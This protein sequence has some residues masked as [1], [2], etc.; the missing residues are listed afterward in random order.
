LTWWGPSSLFGDKSGADAFQCYFEPLSGVSLEDLARLKQP[1]FFPPRW[2]TGN[3]AQTGL[4]KWEGKGSRAGAVY[5]LNRPETV[6]VSDFHIGAVNV[7]PWLPAHHPMAGKSLSDIYR[8]LTARYLKP[9]AEIVAACDAFLA[10]H[11]AQGP[12]VAVHM[13]GSDKALE[14]PGLE[15]AHHALLEALAAVDPSWR[16]LLL[17]DD[18][19]CLARVKDIYGSRV[20][21]TDCQRTSTPEGVHYLA[22]T[23]PLRAGREIMIDTYLALRADRFIGNGLSNVSAMIAVMKDWAAGTC[24]LTGRSLLTDRNLRLY[25]MPVSPAL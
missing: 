14:D 9:R 15:A 19:R 2:N 11:L 4:S 22:A 23:D 5:F 21:A 7:L 12:F 3:L 24:T 13:R 10:A 6:A 1:S 20:A 8:Y 17:T 25:Q 18:A 16:I